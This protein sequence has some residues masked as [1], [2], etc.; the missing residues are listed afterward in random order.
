[1]SAEQI[2]AG[3][4]A[5]MRQYDETMDGCPVNNPKRGK[6]H[7]PNDRCEYCGSTASGMC[8]KAIT[9]G[10]HLQKDIRAILKEPNQ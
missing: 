10:W 4:S 8:G 1:M 7:R 9:A 3:L 6:V 2:A 5:A